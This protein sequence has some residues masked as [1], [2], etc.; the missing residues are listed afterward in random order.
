MI[1]EQDRAVYIEFTLRDIHGNVLDTTEG[2]GPL[3]YIH[4]RGNLIAGLEAFLEGRERGFSGS[5]E[6]APEQA[7]GPRHPEAV[8]EVPRSRVGGDAPVQVGE[9]LQA[10]GPHGSMEF[11]V[12]AVD[13]DTLTLDGNHPLAGQT[14]H[15]DIE[16]VDVQEA[17]ED[18]IKHGRLHPGG[19][20]L[21]VKDSSYDDSLLQDND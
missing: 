17:H 21:M 1:V 12:V 3:G 19:H 16:V 10:Q 6:V 7:Y 8:I 4:G 15:F 13:E 18:E 11:T 9:R 20:H 2:R 5:V 14:L